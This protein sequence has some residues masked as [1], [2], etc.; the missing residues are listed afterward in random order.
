MLWIVRSQSFPALGR[1]FMARLH[2][3]ALAFLGF[4]VRQAPCGTPRS[5]RWSITL[6]YRIASLQAVDWCGTFD[7][8]ASTQRGDTPLARTALHAALQR[9]RSMTKYVTIT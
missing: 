2:R 4:W 9:S 1:M 8:P 6:H 5:A 3:R 7:A